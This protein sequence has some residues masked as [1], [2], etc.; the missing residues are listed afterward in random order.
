MR[1]RPSAPDVQNHSFQGVT[2]GS[3]RIVRW[4]PVS[5]RVPPELAA[6]LGAGSHRI[7]FAV[8]RLADT[9]GVDA[10]RSLHEKSTFV[11]PR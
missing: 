8:E 3:G 10:A 7:E 5:V 4:V 6:R 9:A 11:V 1:R 2:N